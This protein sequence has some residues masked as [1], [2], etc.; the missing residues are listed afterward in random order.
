LV[1][2]TDSE[3][4][5]QLAVELYKRFHA[6]KTYGKEPESLDSITEVFIS[7]LA[8]F[9][10]EKV[11]QAIKTHCQRSDEF[12]TVA[13]IAGLIKRNGK[14]PLS[15]E[16]YIAIQKKDGADRTSEDWQ[17]LRDYE[18]E[19]DDG[20]AGD[21]RDDEKISN[22]RMDNERLR[23][24]VSE[25]ENEAAKAWNEVKKLRLSLGIEKP[26]IDVLDKAK[27]TLET[28]KATGASQEQID[29]FSKQYGIAA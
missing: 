15:K 18:S 12:F 13:D 23:K 6:M 25:L 27:R 28:M 16:R 17:Y 20:W 4:K 21:S 2:R 10:A 26:A 8:E 11:M 22:L 29:E 14:P 1:L 3:G 24:R 5:K 9:P 19:Q 7:D